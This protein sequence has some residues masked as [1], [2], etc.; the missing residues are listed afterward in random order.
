MKQIFILLLFSCLVASGF[1]QPTWIQRTFFSQYS[2]HFQHDSL[3]G[4]R[5]IEIGTDG[6]VYVL[7]YCNQEGEERL[8]KFQPDSGRLLW[9]N[10]IGWHGGNSGQMSNALLTTQ[11]SGC[12]ITINDW[13]TAS[14][15][16]RIEKYGS[17]GALQWSCDFNSVTGPN[18]VLD[19]I[20]NSFGNYYALVGDINVTTLF[21]LDRNGTQIFQTVFPDGFDLY[22][23]LIH[24]SEPTRPY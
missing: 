18:G 5:E 10:Y 23:S 4:M 7:A 12:I 19:V 9:E 2:S 3:T 17:D 22:L 11:D 20:E 1:A 21:E 15:D 24:I 14:N 16:G 13:G 6:S 8:M